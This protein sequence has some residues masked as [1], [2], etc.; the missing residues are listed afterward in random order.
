MSSGL[1]GNWTLSDHTS[2]LRLT[3]NRHQ[4]VE[5]VIFTPKASDPC[6]E[7]AIEYGP[8]EFYDEWRS[9]AG[10]WNISVEVTNSEQFTKVA[11]IV[12]DEKASEVME[13]L[14]L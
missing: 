7:R 5:K 3:N 11:E 4:V 2:R 1:K 14:G 9:S 12:G 6:I 8:Y 10:H 13:A